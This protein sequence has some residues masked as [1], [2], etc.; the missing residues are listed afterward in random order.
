MPFDF[1][2]MIKGARL[3]ERTVLVCLRGDLAADHEQAERELEVARRS[4]A[5]SLDGNGVGELIERIEALQNEMREHSYNFRF[6]GLPRPAW[7]ALYQTHEPRRQDDGEPHPVDREFGFNVETFWHALIRAC[8]IDPVLSDEQWTELDGV[9][10]DRQF[11]GLQEAAWK[12]NQ[13]EV[14][15]PFS[16]LAARLKAGIASD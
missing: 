16:L 4:P 1:T 2:S 9:L 6:R 11:G 12:A 14:D 8:L 3:P 13:G 7:R 10:T 5:T 15:V